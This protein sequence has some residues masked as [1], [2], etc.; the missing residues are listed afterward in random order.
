V[1]GPVTPKIRQSPSA[2][3]SIQLRRSLMLRSVK[4][5]SDVSLVARRALVS[6][7]SLFCHAGRGWQFAHV[8]GLGSPSGPV[9]ARAPD[10]SL[11]AEVTRWKTGMF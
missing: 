5:I 11:I 6:V 4:G 2:C 3:S 9:A 1:S 10:M 7:R 8:D